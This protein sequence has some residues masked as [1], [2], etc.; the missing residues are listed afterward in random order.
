MTTP[1]NPWTIRV[2]EHYLATGETFTTRQATAKFGRPP[3]HCSVGQQLHGAARS[4]YFDI[5]RTTESKRPDTLKFK[6]VDREEHV[7]QRA[8][9]V[10]RQSWFHGLV[11]CRS[12]FELGSTL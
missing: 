11:R 10:Q 9:K 2:H 7:T 1:L 3:N 4:G 5:T 12:I 6:A 8:G